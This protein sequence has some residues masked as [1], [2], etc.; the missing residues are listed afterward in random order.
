MNYANENL[1]KQ[2]AVE[3]LKHRLMKAQIKRY[4]VERAALD[5]KE[6]EAKNAEA[7]VALGELG[8]TVTIPPYELR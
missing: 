5:L 3:G 7:Q 4:R 8:F 1:I 2:L 6:M